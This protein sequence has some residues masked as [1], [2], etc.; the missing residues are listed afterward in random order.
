M[1]TNTCSP[2]PTWQAISN[3]L[4]PADIILSIGQVFQNLWPENK[5][6]IGPAS[7]NNL[8]TILRMRKKQELGP[9]LGKNVYTLFGKFDKMKT[10][11]SNGKYSS[12]FILKISGTFQWPINGPMLNLLARKHFPITLKGRKIPNNFS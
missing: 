6:N 12:F 5:N 7:G 3:H 2:K 10:W 1:P 9:A 11:P 4:R 8:R